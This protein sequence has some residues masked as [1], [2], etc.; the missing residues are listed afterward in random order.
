MGLSL[1]GLAFY[2]PQIL[3]RAGLYTLGLMGALSFTAM[4]AKEDKFL[5]IGG[6]LMAGLTILVLSSF[7][8]MFL[9]ARF[10]TTLSLID[11][12]WLYGGLAIFSG[13]VLYD[14]QKLMARAK[15]NASRG[16]LE[17]V[18]YINES[19]SL[20]MDIINIFIRLVQ[21]LSNSSKK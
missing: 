2:N 6:P 13:F 5:Y 11:A 15:I 19:I 21:I 1:C 7:V 9:P 17:R 10:V 3:F 16:V 12:F 8:G 14:T 20:Y 4:N 18:D